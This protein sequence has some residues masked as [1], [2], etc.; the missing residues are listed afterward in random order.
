[1]SAIALEAPHRLSFDTIGNCGSNRNTRCGNASGVSVAR[2]LPRNTSET[3][4]DRSGF[5]EEKCEVV[6]T[7]SFPSGVST[8]W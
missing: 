6:P 2:S 4:I 1:M 8:L 5:G 3:A 7:H